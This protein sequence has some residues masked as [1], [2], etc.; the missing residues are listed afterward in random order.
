MRHVS[1]RSQISQ[2]I[3]PTKSRIG[4]QGMFGITMTLCNNGVLVFYDLFFFLH[5]ALLLK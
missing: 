2:A 3:A 5:G 1:F 4:G